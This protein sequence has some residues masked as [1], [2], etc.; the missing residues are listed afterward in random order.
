[1]PT[2][3]DYTRLDWSDLV[4]DRPFTNPDHNA[5]DLAHL[6]YMVEKLRHLLHQSSPIPVQPRPYVLYLEEA[7][8]RRHRLALARP[9]ELLTCAELVVVG[10]CGH[11]WP[12]ADR[13]PLDAVDAELL[14]EFMQHPHLLSYSS[15]EVGGGNWRNLVLFS[16][17]QGIGH[18]AISARHA[19]AVRDLAPRY[20]QNIRLHNGVLPGGLMSGQ[21]LLLTRTKYFDYQ[22]QPFWWAVRELQA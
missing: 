11:K 5:E 10:F 2:T 1:M 16:Q 21:E 18:W 22:D 8:G 3:T 19:D 6:R 13:A 17:A 12:E 15:L 7:G 14:T 4:P 9:E 20:Y